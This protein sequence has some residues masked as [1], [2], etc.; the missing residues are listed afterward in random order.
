M[1]AAREAAL[2]A[3]LDLAADDFLAADMAVVGGDVKFVGWECV[4][5][6]SD[7]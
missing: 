1:G 4:A 7:E 6:G 2:L 5:E 3:A